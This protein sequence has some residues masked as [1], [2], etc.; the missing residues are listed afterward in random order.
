MKKLI[1]FEEY[2]IRNKWTSF[3]DS[4][5]H[6]LE[7]I[8]FLCDKFDIQESIEICSIFSYLYKNGFLSYQNKFNFSM[9]ENYDS[10]IEN[11][12][13]G[14]NII[15][16]KGNDKHIT[17]LLN[18]IMHKMNFDSYIIQSRYNEKSLSRGN[19]ILFSILKELYMN[20]NLNFINDETPYFFDATNFEILF[21]NK[22]NKIKCMASNKVQNIE[23]E[24]FINPKFNQKIHKFV[25]ASN[26]Q[27]DDLL[28]KYYRIQYLCET[29]K[30]LLEN[31]YF[32]NFQLFKEMNDYKIK[33]KV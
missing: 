17:S 16:G 19:I 28:S 5:N 32:N 12:L 26:I 29:E 23:K 11:N 4:Y 2:K 6:L 10:F 30:Y 20:H 8:K 15:L 25:S 14:S 24:Y 27:I 18:D 33:R 7:E 3:Q 13:P 9:D 1:N 22:I 21:Q 31:F